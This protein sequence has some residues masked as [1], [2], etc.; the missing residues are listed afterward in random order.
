[1]K[2]GRELNLNSNIQPFLKYGQKI[3]LYTN[4][5]ELWNMAEH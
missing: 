1:M 4:I 5:L 2:C 3:N